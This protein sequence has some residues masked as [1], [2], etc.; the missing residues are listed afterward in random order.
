KRELKRVL[1]HCVV[2]ALVIGMI[3]V[4][5]LWDGSTNH[6]RLVLGAVASAYV[7]RGV[8]MY[9]LKRWRGMP[10]GRRYPLEMAGM[11][12]AH[13]GIAVFLAGVLLS[14]SLS[15]QSDVRL[16]PGQTENVGG[17]QFRFDGVK[18]I[19]GPNWTAEQGTLT[20][21]DQDGDKISV[22]HPQ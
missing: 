16:A 11:L 20:V 6:L 9:A 2:F 4:L 15:V 10:R 13:F 5:M 17:Y 14:E 21:L 19:T 12:L 3:A 7:A 1:V 8:L 18:H 22:L